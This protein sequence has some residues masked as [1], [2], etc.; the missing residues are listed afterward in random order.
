MTDI[1]LP[2]LDYTNRD[3]ESIFA[4][5]KD[6]IQ[7]YV[8]EWTDQNETD[9]GI[10]LLRLFSGM[11]DVLHFYIDRMAS[12]CFLPTAITRASVIKLLKLI[13][14]TPDSAVPA[15]VDLKFT[16]LSTFPDDVTIPEGTECQTPSGGS[17]VPVL[18][19]TTAD[20]IIAAGDLTGTISAMEGQTISEDVAVS[21][22]TKYQEYILAGASI[23][24]DTLA[25]YV[26]EGSGEELWTEVD[27]F[28][29]HGP[30]EKIYVVELT[31]DG[32]VK[33]LFGD[34]GS[35]AA[36]TV[37]ADIRAEYRVGGGL[38]GNVGAD[39]VTELNDIIYHLGNPI[40]VSVTNPLAASGGLEE[41]SIADSKRKGP[42]SLRTRWGLVTEEDYANGAEQ[43]DGVA[44]AHA[45]GEGY[46]TVRIYIAP[47]AGGMP[48]QAL[49][50]AV[51]DYCET[52]KIVTTEIIVE[53]PIYVTV[54]VEGTVHV[55]DNFTQADV[56]AAVLAALT[57]HFSFENRDFGQ[58]VYLSDIYAVIDNVSGVNYV[59]LTKMTM[60]PVVDYI[61]W[62]SDAV[63][64]DFMIVDTTDYETWTIEFLSSTFRVTGA[65]AGLQV[66]TGS[67]NAPYLV[68][69]SSF[70]FTIASGS[71]IP[72]TGDHATVRASRL[73]DNIS[74]L[75]P[76]I[77]TGTIVL[78]FIGGAG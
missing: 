2:P 62:S 50:D 69:D 58:D 52:R 74:I 29:G 43:V 35:G 4:D 30:T 24:D 40:S 28:A 75:D 44:K 16:L 76:E 14:Y 9:P 39:A 10:W 71:H 23:I 57:E 8:D 72:V 19:E 66:N 26:D 56:E 49:K 70:G 22:G 59:D 34:N 33:I 41:E 42:R 18:F 54:D 46:R 36:P 21:D 53:D 45:A 12:E 63:I 7:Y 73:L 55:F 37:N 5:A 64:E 65:V 27:A 6:R 1:Q 68:D 13:D 32:E 47:G 11:H 17:E 15:S 60:E 77:A 31:S 61:L 48:S 3:Q 78:S 51:F 20:L 67:L 38:Y 25:V